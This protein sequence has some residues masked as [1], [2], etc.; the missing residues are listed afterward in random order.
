[1]F[2]LRNLKRKS[3]FFDVDGRSSETFQS[4][5]EKLTPIDAAKQQQQIEQMLWRSR[6]AQE[7]GD[8]Q[9]WLDRSFALNDVD[10]ELT[11]LFTGSPPKDIPKRAWL[12]RPGVRNMGPWA[13]SKDI[14]LDDASK[15]LSGKFADAKFSNTQGS[16]DIYTQGDRTILATPWKDPVDFSTEVFASRKDLI[17]S[18]YAQN[19]GVPEPARDQIAQASRSPKVWPVSSP[20]VI[21]WSSGEGPW[22]VLQSAESPRLSDKDILEVARQDKLAAS[23]GL[24]LSSTPEARKLYEE[25]FQKADGEIK[26]LEAK[27]AQAQKTE[28]YARLSPEQREVA[29]ARTTLSDMRKNFGSLMGRDARWDRSVRTEMRRLFVDIKKL[30]GNLASL[31]QWQS[32][33]TRL[34]WEIKTA[35]ATIDARRGNDTF[36]TLTKQ[37]ESAKATI[38]RT[39]AEMVAL[40]SAN[41][42][43]VAQ[44]QNPSRNEKLA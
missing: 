34:K 31:E 10:R 30:E 7:K 18:Q 8:T 14:V 27:I 36:G 4:S 26:R 15:K 21:A 38:T 43:V 39:E 1:M 44:Y 33:I 16:I 20:K 22:P 11:I 29:D 37:I 17:L 40:R 6:T 5:K 13:S 23:T 2:T 9:Q 3:Q 35:Q 32:E 41:A 25:M 28:E 24:S 12:D 42:P 19:T